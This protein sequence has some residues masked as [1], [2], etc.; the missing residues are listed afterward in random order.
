MTSQRERINNTNKYAKTLGYEPV[1]GKS[2]I[3]TKDGRQY[4]RLGAI[5][6]PDGTPEFVPVVLPSKE[7]GLVT[8]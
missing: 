2:R 5:S 4:Y 6:Y 7:G 3:F 8:D 1:R